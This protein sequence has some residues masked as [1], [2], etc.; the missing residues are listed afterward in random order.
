MLYAKNYTPRQHKILKYWY[1]CDSKHPLAHRSGIVYLHRHVASEKLGRWLRP[2]E[3]VHH[4]DGDKSNNTPDNLVVMTSSEHSHQH[5]GTV[6]D[7]TCRWCGNPFRPSQN[8]VVYCSVECGG[9]GSR[10][11]D[12]GKEELARL[13]WEIPSSKIAERFGVADTAISKR[14]KLLGVEKPP[15][16]YWSRL[17]PDGSLAPVKV[18]TR[19][20]S[21]GTPLGYGKFGCSCS[22]CQEAWTN[23]ERNMSDAGVEHGTHEAY[24][25][26]GCRCDSCREKHSRKKTP[27]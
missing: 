10:K 16:G 11:F 25:R 14:C 27:L 1:F 8:G 19:K 4:L 21:H 17:L 5:H 18:K 15:R 24:N 26:F 23:L 12:I 7:A 13:V 2:D 22:G 9:R 6:V 3:H 20:W